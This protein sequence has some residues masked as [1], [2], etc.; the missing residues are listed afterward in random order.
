MSAE[1]NNGSSRRT[2]GAQATSTPSSPKLTIS[3]PSSPAFGG[4]DPGSPMGLGD[5]DPNIMTSFKPMETNMSYEVPTDKPYK[6]NPAPLDRP[7][8]LYC[9]GI[10][11]LV[12]YGHM[13]ALEQAKKSLPNVYLMVG[14]CNDED[15]HT[16]KGKTVLTENERYESMRHCRWV[17][18]IITDAPW[19]VTQ[20]FLDKHE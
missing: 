1:R 5:C 2:S 16:R 9:D 15:T 6:I 3:R 10:Y 13:R 20:E 11:D 8:R 18:E 17:D 14:M 4:M 7:A 19:I 12:H